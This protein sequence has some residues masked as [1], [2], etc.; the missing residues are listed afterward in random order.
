MLIINY[1]IDVI[2]LVFGVAYC[3]LDYYCDVYLNNNNDKKIRPIH[4]QYI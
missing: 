1:I 3:D 2:S 4:F